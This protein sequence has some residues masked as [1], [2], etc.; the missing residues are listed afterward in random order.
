MNPN[1]MTILE[2]Q[3]LAKESQKFEQA[4]FDYL[5]KPSRESNK[6]FFE[7]YIKF[8]RRVYPR[9]EGTRTFIKRLILDNYNITVEDK[10]EEAK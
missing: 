7:G 9:L 6:N 3:N 8:H 10:L 5:F 2:L 4:L 1:E